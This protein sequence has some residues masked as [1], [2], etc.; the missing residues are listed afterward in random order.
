MMHSIE[1]FQLGMHLLLP[2]SNQQGALPSSVLAVLQ[3]L[4]ALVCHSYWVPGHTF[5]LDQLLQTTPHGG[6]IGYQS[7]DG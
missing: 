1:P 5:G 4:P 2:L 6:R 3:A 7:I